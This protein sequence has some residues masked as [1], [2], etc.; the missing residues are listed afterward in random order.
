MWVSTV[1]HFPCGI[2]FAP[3]NT[4]PLSTSLRLHQ[5]FLELISDPGS[6]LMPHGV[7][8]C[9]TYS[10]LR[11]LKSL[12]PLLIIPPL[13]F[14]SKSPHLC[15]SS[16]WNKASLSV[17][18]SEENDGYSS[19]EDPM[20]S[21]PEDE[22]GKKLV[23]PKSLTFSLWLPIML[24]FSSILLFD[25]ASSNL[26]LNVFGD[27]SGSRKVHGGCGLRE[28][29]TSGAVCQERGHGPANQRRRGGTV[30]NISTFLQS[31]EPKFN[32]M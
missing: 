31:K 14:A 3:Y 21:D 28:G 2:R 30:V 10:S 23:S 26:S 17:D 24:I 19:G 9:D 8:V 20:N 25:A 29:G 18:A 13:S 5:A 15:P 11:S 6:I 7:C 22:V 32:L 27:P 16:G 1:T 12:F 4:F